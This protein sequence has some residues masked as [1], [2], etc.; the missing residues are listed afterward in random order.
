VKII[1]L[2]TFTAFDIFSEMKILV[3]AIALVAYFG[4]QYN[5]E[6]GAYSFRMN[7][8]LVK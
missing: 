5:K 7:N 8:I 4:H 2:F 1:K 6:L 3:I